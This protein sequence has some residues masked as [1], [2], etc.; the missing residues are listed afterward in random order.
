MSELW[1]TLLQIIRELRPGRPDGTPIKLQIE[2]FD[3]DANDLSEPTLQV[4]RDSNENK[5]KFDQEVDRLRVEI[6]LIRR[7]RRGLLPN[8]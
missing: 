3:D 7:G 2:I 4:A 8:G 6:N 1:G 5:Q